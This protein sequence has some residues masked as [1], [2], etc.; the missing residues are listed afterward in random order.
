M[1]SLYDVR[2]ILEPPKSNLPTDDFRIIDSW[3]EYEDSNDPYKKNLKYMCYELEVM[4]PNT[5]AM[6]HFFKAVKFA[7]VC[8]VPQNAKQSTS[9]MKMQEDVLAAMNRNR[10][11]LITIIANIIKP[12]A[13]GL[14]YL[15]GVQGT[16]RTMEKAKR[17]ADLD[18]NGLISAMQGTYRVLRL[19]CAKSEEIEWLKEKMFHMNFLTTAIGIPKANESGED[20]GNKGMGGSNVNPDSEGTLEEIIAGLLDHEYVMEIL[21][22]PVNDNTIEGWHRSNAREMTELNG[23]L[24][25]QKSLNIGLSLPMMYAS[26]ASQ[27]QGWSK[28][29]TDADTY[30][31]GQ[32]E[33][34]TSSEGQSFGE[35]LTETLGTTVGHTTGT[36]NSHS[37]S[38]GISAS[39]GTTDSL[40]INHNIGSNRGMSIGQNHGMSVGQNH[41]INAGMSQGTNVSQSESHNEGSSYNVSHG[42]NV[43]QSHSLGSSQNMGYNHSQNTSIGNSTTVGH[44][45][46]KTTGISL[47]DG[48]STGHNEGFGHNF[49]SN[50]GTSSNESS[51]GNL[52]IGGGLPLGIANINGSFNHSSG[53]GTSQ[54]TSEGTSYSSGSS[55]SHNTGS[56]V[57]SSN[58][59]SDSVSNGVS[60][61]HGEN[62]GVSESFG[63]SESYGTNIGESLSRGWGVNQSDGHSKSI[64][65]SV[66]MN[67]G[68]SY[69]TNIGETSGSSVGLSAGNS[70]SDGLSRSHG[71]TNSKSVSKTIG[72]TYGQSESDS[73]SQSHSTGHGKT[74]GQSTS[75]SNGKS[76]NTSTGN[77][78]GISSGT[79][80]AYSMGASTSMGLGPSIGY[81]KSYQWMDQEVKD[82]LELME[83]QN[84]RLKMATTQGAFYTYVYIACPDEKT[85]A[86]AQTSAK[87]AWHNEVSLIQPLQLLSLTRFEQSHLLYHFAAFS[88]DVTKEDLYGIEKQKYGTVLLPKEY[89]AYTHLPR[90]SAGG[91]YTVV[92]DI[93]KF[94]VPSNMDGEI[95]MG[96]ILNSEVYSFKN[97]YRSPHD[98]RINE[99]GLMHG[100]FTGASRSGKTVAAMRFITELTGIRRKETG[101]RLRIVV[102]D[103]KR[104]WRTLSRFVE[105]ERFRF[106]SMGDPD[107]FPV[108]INPWK[109]PKGVRPQTWIDCVIDVYCRAYGL[110]ELGKQMIAEVVYDLYQEAGVFDDGVDADDIP[111]LSSK[112]NFC[113]VYK[114]MEEKKVKMEDP[115]NA[116]A[117]AGNNTRDAF[118]RLLDRLSCFSRMFSIESILYGTSEGMGIDEMIGDDD[119]TVL[120]S[121]G[122]ERTFQNFI[123]GVITS[124]FYRF[125]LGHNEGFLAEDQYET[126]L[127][128]EEANEVLTGEK[129]GDSISLSGQSEFE[130]ILDQA[131]GYGLFIFAITQKIADMPASIIANCGLVFAGKLKRAEDINVIVRSIGKEERIDDRDLAKWFP[132][133][134]TGYF[135]CQSS[136]TFSIEDAQPILV[137][138]ARLNVNPPKDDELKEILLM[139]KAKEII[140]NDYVVSNF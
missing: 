97:G 52:G 12:V 73:L 70:V 33:S 77:S 16:A 140:S 94:S 103:P 41:G 116:K 40:G 133:S 56:S 114:R 22:T 90:I 7:R 128:I 122:L 10:A 112:V 54:G 93:P 26:N 67:T 63:S 101:K 81:S 28:G 46:G 31:Y 15:Y 21:S 1:L 4:H 27:S 48:Y 96:T 108:K 80:G 98:Y 131:A 19:E 105:P 115:N 75:T 17:Q 38:N 123:F 61:S 29:Y 62:F 119:V 135:V 60:L 14:L 127:V 44:S 68:E 66:S 74:I 39:Q 130:Q 25:G 72:D 76:T 95:Y 24:Q 34:F 37:I 104:D 51:G 126:V 13:L 8:R 120:E 107:F 2:K 71:I 125:A 32:G 100:Y 57:S 136:R 137:Q 121:K 78:K 43:S 23:Q 117:K 118:A 50:K 111:E 132:Q 58:S 64:G 129:S 20:A 138:I 102:M 83:I 134:P 106:Y 49:S 36:S 99:K 47:N 69:G 53:T 86:A 124:G 89:V 88:A 30:S 9:L 3:A 45:F 91:I 79:T 6:T 139:K 55:F 65:N 113:A 18:F 92:P 35:S 42:N 59:Q 87:A 84:Q 82:L 110:L 11:N 109:V 5:G 85:L